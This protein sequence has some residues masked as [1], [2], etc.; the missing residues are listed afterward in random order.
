M[1]KS[2]LTLLLRR[3]VRE[4]AESLVNLIGLS[5]GLIGFAFIALW[6]QDELSYDR[7]FP[8]FDRIVRLTTAKRSETG[9]T[10]SARTVA[11]LARALRQGF[12]EIETVVRL[13]RKEEIVQVGNR[14]TLQ[15][16]ILLTDP[17]FFEVFSYRLSRGN[18][19]TALSEPYSV[20]LTESTARNYFG[21]SDPIGQSLLIYLYDSTGAGAN[22]RVTGL[23]PDPPKNAHFS[24]SMLGS[25]RT[26]EKA[27]P[28]VLTAEGWT[29]PRYYTYLLLK[30]TTDRPALAG[31]MARFTGKLPGERLNDGRP[32]FS[33]RLQ[34]LADIHLHSHLEN[35]LTANGSATQ[36]FLFSTVGLLILL[37]A[38]I[39]YMNLATARAVGRAREVGIRKAVGAQKTQLIAQFLGESAGVALLALIPAITASTLLQPYF[40]RITGKDLSLLSQ[41]PLLLFLIGVTVLVGLL[42]GLYPAF[43]LSSFRPAGTLKGG[44][45]PGTGNVRLRQTLIVAQFFVTLVLITCIVVI[46]AQMRYIKHKDLGY[47]RDALLMVR[48]NGNAGV[49]QGYEAFRNE[50]R[51]SPLIAGVATSNAFIT[52]GLDTAP[53]ATVDDA[54]QP[55]ELPAARLEVDSDFLNV[56]GLT[57]IAGRNLSP[58]AAGDSV[59]P[60]ILNETAV[61]KAGWKNAE[62][63]LGKPF[64]LD[65]RPGTVI[66]VVRDFHFSTLRHAIQP[67]AVFARDGYFSRITIRIHPRQMGP[68]LALIENAWKKHFPVVLFDFSF[69][70][71]QLEEQYRAEERFSTLLLAFSVLSLL[72]ACLGLYGLIAYLTARRTKEIG[73]RKVLGAT[74]EGIALL[75]S[76]DLLKLVV[77]AGFLAAPVATY[78]LHRWLENFA[79]RVEL[80]W[81]MFAGAGLLVFLPA[82]LTVSYESIKA[83]L[84]DPVRSLRSD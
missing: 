8:N 24:F 79:Y 44:F 57:L 13:E 5:A 27:R 43:A 60:V 4:K 14:Q 58:R 7:I 71:R 54:G 48:H 41:P 1:L 39:N 25:F 52:S 28:G 64:A 33:Y 84:A 21:D 68:A 38:G 2:Y 78:L 45:R 35:E 55:V 40:Y 23:V 75:L 69:A 77:P 20:V 70:D 3:I 62:A 34:P 17:S 56:Y 36:V 12:A 29:D 81:W 22:Y 80:Q 42:S 30:E 66:G 19:A 82:L 6:V 65:G 76:G 50:L 26:V 83:A 46:Y 72:I 51:S 16:G 61:R 63:A 37:L 15:A 10:E 53:A 18:T 47:D 73:I 11:P 49:V 74:T 67:L 31:K 32:A 59:R 9:L